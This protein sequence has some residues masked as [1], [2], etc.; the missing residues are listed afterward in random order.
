VEAFVDQRFSR[1]KY[2]AAKTLAQF[3]SRLRDE[4]DVAALSDE[5]V[6][7]VRETLQ[8]AHVSLWLRPVPKGAENEELGELRG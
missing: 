3:S 2:D 8:P 4:T 1:R 5:L 7:V 6:A